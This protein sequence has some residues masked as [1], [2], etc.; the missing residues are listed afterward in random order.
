MEKNKKTF[1]ELLD[2]YKR[3]G[4]KLEMYLGYQTSITK[5]I[6]FLLEQK[7]LY[8]LMNNSYGAKGVERINRLH[9]M[10]RNRSGYCHKVVIEC[11]K[12]QRE[13]F[14]KK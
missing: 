12:K 11:A 7:K 14:N 2:E 6:R 5:A 10:L 8:C 13:L 9:E 4:A 1:M 3:Y